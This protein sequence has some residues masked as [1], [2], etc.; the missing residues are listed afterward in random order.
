MSMKGEH[1][2]TG[3]F[4][5][6]AV[7]EDGYLITKPEGVYL[8]ADPT[9]GDGDQHRLRLTVDGKLMVYDPV[10][11]GKVDDIED[12]LDHP[13]YG[14]AALET[15]VDE[16]EPRLVTGLQTGM[17]LADHLLAGNLTRNPGFETGDTTGWA[18]AGTGSW[19]V[20]NVTVKTGTYAADLNPDANQLYIIYDIDPRP[21]YAGRRVR[22]QAWL[23][24]D[25][26]ITLS[27]LRIVWCDQAGTAF[28]VSN[29]PDYG[30]NYDWTFRKEVFTA[31]DGTYFFYLNVEFKSGGT[32]GHGYAD[33][34]LSPQAPMDGELHEYAV[35]ISDIWPDD[36]SKTCT[37]TSGVA[38]HTF[39][40]WAD[41]VDSVAAALSAKFAASDGY[42]EAILIE[43][44]SATDNLY[45][46]ELR[47]NA[48]GETIGRVRFMKIGA[49][50]DVSHQTPI[51]S[52]RIPA[53]A[54]IEYR[55][56]DATGG[57]TAELHIRYYL[58]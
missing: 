44:C 27:M 29:S 7:D 42:I 56:K 12:K 24:A 51:R 46:L 17:T 16:L 57:A 43:D 1:K 15:L 22:L 37:V 21:C 28:A 54:D 10:I 33:A 35:H 9:L 36:T 53:G 18:G 26:N 11:D 20:Q 19:S 13:T 48:T 41:L 39:G 58:V 49:K 5:R 23:K 25:A 4:I 40:A 55:M 50:V 14:L 6:V 47:N 34:V 30:G 31:P 32:A 2:A 3:E 52:I 45:M 38:A 8:V